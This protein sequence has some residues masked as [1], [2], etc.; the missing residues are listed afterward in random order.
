MLTYL[1]FNA[2]DLAYHQ[3]GGGLEGR[4]RPDL[5]NREQFLGSAKIVTALIALIL[6]VFAFRGGPRWMARLSLIVGVL[7]LVIA[8]TILI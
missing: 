2:H 6:A 7:G 3:P 4:I 8:T 1:Y 5:V